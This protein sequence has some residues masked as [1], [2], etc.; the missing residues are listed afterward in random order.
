M[1]S[2]GSPERGSKKSGGNIRRCGRFCFPCTIRVEQLEM[3]VCM[4]W[5]SERPTLWR[6]LAC[7]CRRW[8]L[9]DSI[10]KNGEILT[11]QYKHD[12]LT[13]LGSLRCA[14]GVPSPALVLQSHGKTS[15]RQVSYFI[16]YSQT[17]SVHCSG[18]GSD[19]SR[20]GMFK[21]DLEISSFAR[22][23]YLLSRESGQDQKIG[24]ARF[25]K[26]FQDTGA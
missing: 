15:A 26:F 3:L 17:P 12:R 16:P 8:S 19:T 4:R 21:G 14:R 7:E 1:K 5:K 23:S 20:T 10:A 22:P 13:T 6:R 24:G 9:V 18:K 25:R 11:L 2:F